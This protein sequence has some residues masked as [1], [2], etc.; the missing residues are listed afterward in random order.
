MDAQQIGSLVLAV[1]RATHQVV[2]A[3]DP[4]ARRLGLT[5]VEMNVLANLA[6]VDQS[7]A[8][9][10]SRATGLRPSTLTGVLDR[11]ESAGL[12]VRRPHPRDR[13]AITLTLT[14]TGRT[15]TR[16]VLQALSRFEDS[17][18]DRVPAVAVQGFLAVLAAIGADPIQQEDN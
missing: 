4:D 13:R 9:G 6:H 1:E 7:T 2:A 5:P 15:R 3:L 16:Q 12:V 14:R 10:L 8:A 11:L 17:V 18:V